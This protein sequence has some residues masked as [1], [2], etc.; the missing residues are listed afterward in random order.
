M[1]ARAAALA[2]LLAALPLA[3][4]AAEDPAHGLWRTEATEAGE[5]LEV[6]LAPCDGAPAETCGVIRR[7]V[8]P[9]GEAP[10]YP[11]LGRTMIEGMTRDGRDYA[12]GTIWAPDDD[13]TYR[14][15]MTL[16]ADGA[17]LE[18]EGCV[19]VFCRGQDWTRV[20]AD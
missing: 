13:E 14:S 6:E 18:V 8:T 19:L 12:G 17:V 2:A 10:G 3:A 9:S 4:P 5:Y 15:N 7:A 16:S 1:P 20:A 11:H